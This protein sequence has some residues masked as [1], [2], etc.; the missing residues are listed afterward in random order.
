MT[1]LPLALDWRLHAACAVVCAL[2]AVAD[3]L[4]GYPWVALIC[5]FTSGMCFTTAIDYRHCRKYS[6]Y[7]TNSQ[8]A[9]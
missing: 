9:R 3:V 6:R 2:G 8:G 7:F 1:D 4:L 5:A